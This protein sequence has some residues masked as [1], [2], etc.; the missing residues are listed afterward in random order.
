MNILVNNR[1]KSQGFIPIRYMMYISIIFLTS[2]DARWSILDWIQNGM[3]L[4][5]DVTCITCIKEP[6]NTY[7]VV[8][9]HGF[10]DECE[11]NL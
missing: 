10:N 8:F 5:D 7:P 2:V 1:G 6:E 11:N 9:F 3:H 4:F